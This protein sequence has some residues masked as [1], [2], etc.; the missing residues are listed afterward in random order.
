MNDLPGAL[1]PGDRIRRLPQEN[2]HRPDTR[3]TDRNIIFSAARL[4]RSASSQLWQR[5]RRNKPAGKPV[6]SAD[7][8]HCPPTRPPP[9]SSRRGTPT[10]LQLL[11]YVIG[12]DDSL[13]IDG[14]E[15]A[16]ALWRPAGAA[17]R[18]IT[19]PLIGD[20]LAA[21]LHPDATGSGSHLPS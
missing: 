21:G 1:L 12:A 11:D 18:M 14:M 19:L 17:G 6:L 4:F 10:S 7:P 9:S 5:L 16:A 8:S 20:I 13:Q 3:V 15:R 2:G